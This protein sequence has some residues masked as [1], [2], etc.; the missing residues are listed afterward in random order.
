[1]DSGAGDDFSGTVAYWLFIFGGEVQCSTSC[2]NWGLRLA[3]AGCGK[4]PTNDERLLGEQPGGLPEI[5]EISTI[6]RPRY[7]GGTPEG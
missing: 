5:N 3:F 1:L 2:R 4:V 6:L 7:E